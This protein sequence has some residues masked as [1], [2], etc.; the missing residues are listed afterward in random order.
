MNPRH[1]NPA[2][3]PR[4]ADSHAAFALRGRCSPIANGRILAVGTRRVARHAAARLRVL[5]L[6][7][8]LS[9]RAG[10]LPHPLFLL[11]LNRRLSSMCR[12]CLAKQHVAPVYTST[13]RRSARDWVLGADSITIVEHGFRARPISTL[14]QHPVMSQPDDTA[15]LNSAALQRPG[16]SANADPPG[17]RL[18]AT[19]LR[20]LTGIVREAAI[21]ALPD[22]VREFARRTDAHATPSSTKARDP[23]MRSL[24]RRHRGS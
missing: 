11:A 12:C 14:F 18:Y 23:H 22:P 6:P 4:P 9:R 15:W 20:P 21:N 24:G 13:H 8:G 19:A 1:L 7:G 16:F 2:C 5:D 10:R 17:G 3:S